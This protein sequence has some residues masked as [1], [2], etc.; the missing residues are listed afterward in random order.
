LAS[1]GRLF[2]GAGMPCHW[3]NSLFAE[4]IEFE[5][6]TKNVAELLDAVFPKVKIELVVVEKS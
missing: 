5:I 1:A 3:T 2:A 6:I 4:A